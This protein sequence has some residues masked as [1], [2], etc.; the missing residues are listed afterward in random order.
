[1]SVPLAPHSPRD[2]TARPHALAPP[3]IAAELA[4][5]AERGLTLGEASARLKR[6][7]P[8]ALRELPPTPRWKR[9]LSQLRG[10]LVGLL[11]AAAVVSAAMREWPETIAILVIVLL[12]ALLGFLQEE[13][14]AHSIAKLA[15]L[16]A[17]TA[18]VVREGRAFV[19]A[20]RDLV[21]GDLIL[22]EAGDRVPADSRLV[23]S[24]GFRTQE[25]ALTGESTPVAKQS[26]SAL[27]EDTDLADRTNMVYLGTHAVAGSARALITATGMDTELGRIAE[28]IAE[29]PR[30]E[31]PLKRRF[32][33]M[34]LLLAAICVALVG[35]VFAMEA[36]RGRDLMEVLL[37]SVSLAVAAVPEGLPAAV[38][39]TLAIGLQR[40][41]HRHALV[42]TLSS[43]ETLG[44]VTVICSDK[45][46]TLTRNEMTVRA[47]F[48][49][50]VLYRVTGTGYAPTGRFVRT[51]GQGPLRDDA[52]PGDEVD[53]ASDPALLAALDVA[54]TCN[55]ASLE[56][57][58]AGRHSVV[59]DP[60]EGALLVAA[61]KAGVERG[62]TGGRV[63]SEI[64]FDPQRRA[65]SVI[66]RTD[67]GAIVM[68]TKG[69]PE[70]I[71]PMCDRALIAGR[72]V[73]LD[74]DA[75][76]RILETAARMA[77]QALRVLG[78]ALRRAPETEQGTFAERGLVFAGLAGMID[79]PREEAREAVRR[80]RAAGIRPVM[81]TGDHASTA[82]AIARELEIA[83]AGDAVIT[84]SHLEGMTDDELAVAAGTTVVYARVS[85][86]D[87]LRLVQ[88]LKRR[89]ELVA[90]TGDGVNDA[91][92]VKTADIGIA[93]GLTGTDVTREA[94]DI[95][96]ADDNFAS[97]V[98]AVE[99]GRVIYD[100][101]RKF[102]YYLLACNVSELALML[103]ASA[104]G[105]PVPLSPTQILWINLVTDGPPALALAMEPAEP[106]VMERRPR[107]PS[108]PV[109]TRRRWVW[110]LVQ[111]ALM[112][113]VAAAAFRWTWRGD[114]GNLEV[115]RVTVFS[116]MALMQIAFI[117]GCRSPRR[118]MPTVGALSNPYLLWSVALA[119]LL[120]GAALFLPWAAPFFDT[121]RAEEAP[122]LL[123]AGS[124]LVP[125][126]LV[127]A[128]KL[129]RAALRRR[130]V[131]GR[132]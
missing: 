89:G 8:N 39:F 30:H 36:F 130:A 21:A 44:S 49:G 48:A 4:T 83:G 92:A 56:Q 118:T 14:A 23:S 26:A 2:A 40:L 75:R 35:L 114:A 68:Y 108:E 82:L 71:L 55:H 129:L 81:I 32:E 38:T 57:D 60:T 106:D 42:R 86:G 3:R 25:A 105:W 31:A 77:E 9:F 46:G 1:M 95:V 94:S 113:A 16:T 33:E 62:R 120:L 80:C 5:D 101:I 45:T 37:I 123:I 124:A 41:A 50:D 43:V 72:E 107:S 128:A 119:I 76:R 70:V 15:H 126:T 99:Q 34:G 93:M 12:N 109:I 20:A 91:P 100:N 98:N 85:A 27:A 87:K 59:G 117:F 69:A 52:G 127:E 79:P 61:L 112:A 102:V 6:D 7:G 97:I 131:P 51:D 122:W 132:S 111:G 66:T 11:I 53:A 88:T 67:S 78:L 65:M 63:L 74:E 47:L 115:A 10:I 54:A 125:V 13:K 22:L 73:P 90:M 84:G 17:P 24:F 28:W 103:G 121:H 19:V 116:S 96:L 104:A 64:P 29:A 18:R 110:L 58:D